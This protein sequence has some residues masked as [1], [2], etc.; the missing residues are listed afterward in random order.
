MDAQ[1]QIYLDH[2]EELKARLF[3][4]DSL[5]D[6]TKLHEAD[7]PD[8]EM[9]ALH[10]RKL[11]EL[12]AFSSLVAHKQ[13]YA[14]AYAKYSAHWNAKRLL[15]NLRSINADFYPRP[16]Q[17]AKRREDEP[18]RFDYVESGYLT[19][20]EFVALYERTSA[21]LHVRSPFSNSFDEGL[22]SPINVWRNRIV[23]LM[24]LHK[25]KL[26]DVPQHWIVM[27]ASAEHKRASLLAVIKYDDEAI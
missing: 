5:L 19:T 25:I 10:L 1:A 20:D 4:L 8:Y 15:E 14:E 6:N 3:M 12:I 23:T 7:L 18:L 2:M 26:V 27:L 17:L 24:R 11:L 21:V 9:A 22:G 16:I 13:T